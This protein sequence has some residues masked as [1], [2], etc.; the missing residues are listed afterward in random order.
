[1]C[2]KVCES[3]CARSFECHRESMRRMNVLV[4]ARARVSACVISRSGENNY[5]YGYK[6]MVVFEIYIYNFYNCFIEV[7][8]FGVTC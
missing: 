3:F 7:C 8:Y 2:Q 5:V 6:C 1:M 4:Y